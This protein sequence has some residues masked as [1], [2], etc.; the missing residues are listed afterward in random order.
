[1]S[2]SFKNLWSRFA[3][4]LTSSA[5]KK[6]AP[7]SHRARLQVEDLESRLTEK[8]EKTMGVRGNTIVAFALSK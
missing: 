1:M 4:T 6:R 7:A 8:V 3:R 2:F 5:P